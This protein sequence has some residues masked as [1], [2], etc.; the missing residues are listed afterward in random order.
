MKRIVIVLGMACLM[1]GFYQ[2]K[3]GDQT[4]KI[5]KKVDP[6]LPSRYDS[7]NWFTS[8]KN[9]K[10]SKKDTRT[11]QNQ[12]N[13][14]YDKFWLSGHVSGG[15]LVAK[16]GQILFEGYNGFADVEKQIPLTADTPIH[17]ASISKVLTSLLVLKLVE[18][19]KLTLDQTV[20]SVLPSF[21]YPETT[22]RNLLSHR[23]G[24]PNYA[25]VIDNQKLWDKTQ[26]IDN[27]GVL[28]LFA[29]NKVDLISKPNTKFMY[30]NTNFALLALIVEKTAKMPFPKAMKY[31]L[32]DP[33]GMKHTFVFEFDRDKDKVSSSYGFKGT[34]WAWDHLDKVYG[35]K[36]VY[37]TPRDLYRLDFAMYSKKF[38]PKQLLDEAFTGYSYES[39]GIKNYGLG[40]RMMEYEN[41]NKFLYHNG[42]WHGNYS[43]YVHDPKN[44][45]AI[46]AFGNQQNRRVYDAFKLV[47]IF[48]NDYPIT[49]TAPNSMDG[50]GPAGNVVKQDTVKK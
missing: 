14:F 34:K 49:L 41:G 7:I 3:K 32:L 50:G 48:S 16:D 2:C 13:D 29:N 6:N 11:Y 30:S 4:E 36:N 18:H 31:M 5:A 28:D 35:D 39:K 23:S 43:V 38:L 47:G 33:I 17:I 20:Q 42:W 25:H 19:K 26:Q 37:S 21:P 8:F 15:M 40:F 44:H 27:Q 12:I 46:I 45:V 10:L 22:I 24:L 1:T 9:K